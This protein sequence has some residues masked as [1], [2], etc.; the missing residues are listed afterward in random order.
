MKRGVYG[1]IVLDVFLACLCA[2]SIASQ[3]L[4]LGGIPVG[5]SE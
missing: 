4:P 1:L 2:V 3:S 5:T